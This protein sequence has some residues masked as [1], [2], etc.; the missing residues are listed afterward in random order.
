ML[1]SS[2]SEQQKDWRT[3]I[4][5]AKRNV[6]ILGSA[7]RDFHNFNVF[8]RRNKRYNVVGFTGSQQIPGISGKTYPPN[9]SGELYPDGIPIFAE[10]EL[11]RL[12]KEL[13]V[14]DCIFAYSDVPYQHVMHIGAIANAA[15]ATYT[16][17][18]PKDTMLKSRCPVIAV[19]AVRTGAGKSQ[20]SRKIIG[21]LKQK[22]LK[23]IAVRHPMP[24]GELRKQRVQRLVTLAD[25][26]KHNCTIEEIE[27]Y[28]PHLVRGTIVYAG[29]DYEAIL[30]AAENDPDGC[31]VVLWDGGNNDFPFYRPDLMVTVADP[32]RAGHEFLYY[33]GE[34]NLRMADVVVINKI[35]SAEPENVRKVKENIAAAN[36][37]A[38]IVSA[39][40]AIHV[41]DPKL[42]KGK[43]VL[44][45]ED[46]PTTTHGGMPYGAGT[47]A[48]RRAGARELVDPRPYAVKSIA[49]TYKKYPGIG[50]LL[51]AMGYSPHQLEH[52]EATID[53]ADCDTVVVAT[54]IDL[55]RIINI[56]KPNTRVSYE[57]QELGKP[58]LEDILS[59]FARAHR[60]GRGARGTASPAK[61][62]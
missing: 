19:C 42:I 60:P 62:R 61:K 45:I 21:L 12:I 14:D 43:R 33:A 56:H 40:S 15:G 31:D 48:A 11:P 35:D 38:T 1:I 6:I 17:L 10:E 59:E 29:A 13:R 39:N 7:G 22:G 34:I 2:F 8:F 27:E 5:M 37:G 18:G 28:E 20:T 54:P 44:V 46:G 25:L 49:D 58:D 53:R 9:L 41:D 52:L 16:L 55:S 36:P 30:R 3:I 32:H 50:P 24:Y 47:I 4:V 57:L 23:A 26:K 51:P